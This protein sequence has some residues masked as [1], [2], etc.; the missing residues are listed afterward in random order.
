MLLGAAMVMANPV[1][2]SRRKIDSAVMLA[3]VV[4]SSYL[5]PS[6]SFL[7]TDTDPDF[8]ASCAAVAPVLTGERIS[9]AHEKAQR[10]GGQVASTVIEEVPETVIKDR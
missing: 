8:Q 1:A 6:I 9:G 3:A 4:V 7:T 2:Q 10:S 5:F